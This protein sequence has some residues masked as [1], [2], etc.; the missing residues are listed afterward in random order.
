MPENL[1]GRL[2]GGARGQGT[3]YGGSVRRRGPDHGV[4]CALVKGAIH[5]SDSESFWQ[6]IAKSYPHNPWDPMWD[7]DDETYQQL[8]DGL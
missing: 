7:D 8:F 5:S 4:R 3:G 1:S 2:V 6:A